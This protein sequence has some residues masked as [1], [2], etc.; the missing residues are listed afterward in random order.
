[1]DWVVVVDDGTVELELNQNS[2]LAVES[3]VSLQQ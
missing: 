1:M 3:V 2:F